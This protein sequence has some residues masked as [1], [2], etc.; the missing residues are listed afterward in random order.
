MS[1]HTHLAFL[2][3]DLI[4]TFL[5]IFFNLF[6]LCFFFNDSTKEAEIHYRVKALSSTSEGEDVA[7]VTCDFSTKIK[8]EAN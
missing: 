8:Y 3:L 1:C 7:L 5:C 6:L 4:F 2:M